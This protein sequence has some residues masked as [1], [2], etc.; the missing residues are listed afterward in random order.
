MCA[1]GEFK[2][3]KLTFHK[4]KHFLRYRELLH[5]PLRVRPLARLKLS[6]LHNLVIKEKFVYSRTGITRNIKYLIESVELYE[7]ELTEL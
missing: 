5:Q 4:V 3:S 7:V 1:A 6:K 2:I